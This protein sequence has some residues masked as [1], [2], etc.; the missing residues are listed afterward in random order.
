M[1][2]KCELQ[3]PFICF[4]RSE[5]AS[6]ASLKEEYGWTKST[7]NGMDEESAGVDKRPCGQHK[8]K[9]IFMSWPLYLA[10]N[11]SQIVRKAQVSKGF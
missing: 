9:K 8:I 5:T 3:T 6:A 7:R 1:L 4:T 10:V 11:G 2:A